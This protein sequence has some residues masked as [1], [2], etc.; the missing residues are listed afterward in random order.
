M[1]IATSL[2]LRGLFADVIKMPYKNRTDTDYLVPK[3]S[4][5]LPFNKHP[6]W[7]DRVVEKILF[8]ISFHKLDVGTLGHF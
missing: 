8:L 3:I 5:E 6:Y 4:R 7:S 1:S 2:T